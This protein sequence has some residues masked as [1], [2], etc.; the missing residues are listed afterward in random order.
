MEPSLKS[1][2][3]ETARELWDT[4]KFALLAVLIVVPIRMFLFQ[5]FIVSGESMHPTFEDGNYLIVDEISYRFHAPNRGDVVIFRYPNDP[6]RLFIKRIIGL[7]GETVV[8]KD[9]SVYIKN[10]D[11]PEGIKLDEPYLSQA[12]LPGGLSSVEVTPEH[13]FVMGDNRGF[14]SD[15]R[16]WGLLPKENLIGN[17]AIRL[18]PLSNISWK[19]GSLDKY[20]Q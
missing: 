11:H 16:S 9:K 4:I 3:Q 17:A 8:F 6:K 14:S 2:R 10:N 20:T 7:P 5:P 18:L 19:P 1:S 13:Y 15:S 12:T